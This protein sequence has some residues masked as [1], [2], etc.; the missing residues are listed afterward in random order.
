MMTQRRR[1]ATQFLRL[2]RHGVPM[3]PLL[4]A[5]GLPIVCSREHKAISMLWPGFMP[6]VLLERS[7]LIVGSCTFN[8]ISVCGR[9]IGFCSALR[10]WFSRRSNSPLP[11]Q[12]R[13]TLLR[14]LCFRQSDLACAAFAQKRGAD[15]AH[16]T[17]VGGGDGF[18]GSEGTPH[19]TAA[20]GRPKD[21]G[22]RPGDHAS[23]RLRAGG[24][25]TTQG[26]SVCALREGN[27]CFL[28]RGA[29]H[30]PTYQLAGRTPKPTAIMNIDA[31]AG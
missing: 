17:A 6:L 13:C 21:H 10:L 8:Q 29:D 5:V 12:A 7:R 3:V 30:Y 22:S 20:P 24:G 31:Q 18:A 14:D 25:A 4:I 15:N 19:S 27:C 23:A 28:R 16:R 26:H 1:D 11:N 9:G 2:N